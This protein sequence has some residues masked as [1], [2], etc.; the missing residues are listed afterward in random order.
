M[1]MSCFLI[2]TLFLVSD[3]CPR[4]CATLLESLKTADCMGT[5]DDAMSADRA[6]CAKKKAEEIYSWA[7]GGCRISG[8]D[9]WVK[10]KDLDSLEEVVEFT[11]DQKKEKPRKQTCMQEEV[12]VNGQCVRHGCEQDDVLDD[13]GN[14]VAACEETQIRV[15]GECM[16][17]REERIGLITKTVLKTK[18]VIKKL[19]TTAFFKKLK[20]EGLFELIDVKILPIGPTT[21]LLDKLK[22]STEKLIFGI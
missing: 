15:N 21:L 19:K 4:F 18:K 1:S 10:C 11:I 7:T 14:C 13:D 9:I 17:M 12:L 2:I 8:N 6:N 16:D 5:S 3:L 22:G 20:S